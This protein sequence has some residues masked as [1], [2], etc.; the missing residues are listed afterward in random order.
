MVANQWLVYGKDG[1]C[2]ATTSKKIEDLDLEPL[3]QNVLI[4]GLN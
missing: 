4:S 1:R 2:M 3:A